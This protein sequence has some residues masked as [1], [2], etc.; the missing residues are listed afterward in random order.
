MLFTEA[1]ANTP[2]RKERSGKCTHQTFLLVSEQSPGN[3]G[4]GEN[5]WSLDFISNMDDKKQY[6]YCHREILVA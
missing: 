3:I 6:A 4:S 5:C 1:V 2:F